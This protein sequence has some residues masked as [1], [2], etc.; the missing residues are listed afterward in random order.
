VLVGPWVRRVDQAQHVS[1][2]YISAP[3]SRGMA[4]ANQGDCT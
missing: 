3:R 4:F 1:T 2:Y